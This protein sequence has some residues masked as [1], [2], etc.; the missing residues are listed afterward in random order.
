M[1]SRRVASSEQLKTN[2]RPPQE[3]EGQPGLRRAFIRGMHSNQGHEGGPR[4]T[5]PQP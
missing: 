3:R 4:N 1:E 2:I 5:E